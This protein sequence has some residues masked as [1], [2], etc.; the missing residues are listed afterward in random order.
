M[1]TF[2]NVVFKNS[3]FNSTT[4]VENCNDDL[5]SNQFEKQ[6]KFDTV[7]LK[8]YALLQDE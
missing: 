6:Q 4:F 7:E 5:I 2:E 3:S 1:Y 8:R